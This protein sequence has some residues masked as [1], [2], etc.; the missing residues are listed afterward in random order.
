[1]STDEINALIA[2]IGAD[3]ALR[4]ALL[5]APSLQ[6][7]YAIA[8][9]HGIDLRDL[10]VIDELSDSMLEK[11]AGGSTDIHNSTMGCAIG[12]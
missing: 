12:C 5:N 10:D 6:A 7:A 9:D 11:V 4:E 3:P 8:A 1:M 2:R